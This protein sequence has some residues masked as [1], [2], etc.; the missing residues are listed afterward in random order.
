[1]IRGFPAA[2][3]ALTALAAVS[4]AACNLA[5]D[6]HVPDTVIP[7]AYK[8]DTSDWKQARP[9]DE[10]PKGAWWL[11]FKDERLDGLED[12]VASANQD[13]RAAYA[14]FQQARAQVEVAGSAAYP[15]VN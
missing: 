3:V 6:Y 13:L 4:L 15:Q 1:M 9:A 7:A 14:R 11:L 12:K 5:P 8:E 2:S 10:M